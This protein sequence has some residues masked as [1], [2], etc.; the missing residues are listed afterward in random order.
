MRSVRSVALAAALVIVVPPIA[1]T[2]TPAAY[3]QAK[4]PV[5]DQL[6]LEARGHWDAA[7]ALAAKKNWDG[8]RTSFKAA[9][10]L[11]KNPRVL[12]NVAIAEKEL[13]RYPAAIEALRRELAEGKGQLT[14]E[15]EKDVESF[16]VQSGT[17]FFTEQQNALARRK[18]FDF[19]RRHLNRS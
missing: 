19:L 15:E 8:A 10:D 9:Y 4:K 13:E 16:I 12:L 2:W 5:R 3:A 6:P 11:S 18:L 14:K 1:L 7:L 17:H